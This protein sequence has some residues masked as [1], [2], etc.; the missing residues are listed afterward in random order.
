MIV[1]KIAHG[2][3]RIRRIFADLICVSPHKSMF[4]SALLLN[5]V[6]DVEKIKELITNCTNKRI[7]RINPRK[8][9]EIRDKK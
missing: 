5:L 7:S 2:L 1:K 6:T 8:I 4:I 3:A 9:S